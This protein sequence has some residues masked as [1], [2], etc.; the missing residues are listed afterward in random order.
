M[1]VDHKADKSNIETE[2]NSD[3]DNEDDNNSDPTPDVCFHQVSHH[4]NKDTGRLNPY[5]ILLDNQITVHMFSNRALL[6]NI[7]DADKPINV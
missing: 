7:K 5:W 3:S 2:Y 4:M 1:H 6:E